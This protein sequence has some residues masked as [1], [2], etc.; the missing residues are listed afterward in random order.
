[1]SESFVGF[2]PAILESVPLFVKLRKPDGQIQAL[3]LEPVGQRSG[4]G[5][6][7]SCLMVSRGNLQ[8]ARHSVECY[9]RQDYPN[10]ELIVV[11]ASPEP[12]FEQFLRTLEQARVRLI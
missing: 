9:L 4:P 7:V 12:E 10:R 8:I 11:S 6:L 2:T 3:R 1:M 5:P